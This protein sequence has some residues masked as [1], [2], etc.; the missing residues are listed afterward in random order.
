[1]EFSIIPSLSVFSLSSAF[2]RRHSSTIDGK[3]SKFEV[4]RFDLG[5]FRSIWAES[6]PHLLRRIQ[7]HSLGRHAAENLLS[8]PPN[9][10]S[11]ILERYG[12]VRREQQLT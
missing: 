1:M 10:S 7:S 4:G 3:T 12:D 9:R 2:S 11:G 5:L 6:V 8:F